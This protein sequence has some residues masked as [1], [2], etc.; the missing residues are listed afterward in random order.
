MLY[1]SCLVCYMY[2]YDCVYINKRLICVCEPSQTPKLVN[3]R[4][5]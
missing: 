3:N 1:T 4:L 5:V 2:R